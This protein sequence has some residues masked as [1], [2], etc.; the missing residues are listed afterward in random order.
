MTESQDV[1][2]SGQVCQN[3]GEPLARHHVGPCPRCGSRH[4]RYYVHLETTVETRA[5]LRSK[6]MVERISNEWSWFWICV[7]IV[8]DIAGLVAAYFLS[9]WFSVGITVLLDLVSCAVGVK[10]YQKV[11]TR[12]S[13]E[14]I[15]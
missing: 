7:L 1:T 3:C 14:T 2:V 13:K 11:V 9:G 10:V 15:S 5:S 12:E 4:K 6:S 8:M